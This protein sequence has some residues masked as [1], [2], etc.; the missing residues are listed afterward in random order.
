[1]A[2]SVGRSEISG[3][4]NSLPGNWRHSQLG[5]SHHVLL[6]SLKVLI[7]FRVRACDNLAIRQEI[8]LS[9]YKYFYLELFL[10]K[11]QITSMGGN[12]MLTYIAKSTLFR[13]AWFVAYFPCTG[14]LRRF[15]HQ[16]SKANGGIRF[17]IGLILRIMVL[18]MVQGHL[19][20]SLSGKV[21][22]A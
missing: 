8:V 21:G 14:M 1:M 13:V 20:W 12:K 11:Q 17:V 2:K 18:R 22:W 4:L 10:I 6:V 16:C 9:K 7:I 5:G 3:L 15:C 19:S